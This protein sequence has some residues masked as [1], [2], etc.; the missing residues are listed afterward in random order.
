MSDGGTYM[1]G[2]K[3]TKESI[4]NVLKKIAKHDSYHDAI[5]AADKSV[6]H[7]TVMELA[8]RLRKANIEEIGF[9]TERKILKK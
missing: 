1:D 3:L 6:P 7:G 4:G 2:V 9:L 5:I 8:D